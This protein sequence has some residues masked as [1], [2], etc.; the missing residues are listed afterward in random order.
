MNSWLVG[1]LI[2]WFV[3]W[4]IWLIAVWF[5]SLIHWSVD[6]SVGGLVGWVRGWMFD[7]AWD[8][9]LENVFVMC[10]GVVYDVPGMPYA[11][12]RSLKRVGDGIVI[13]LPR[14]QNV[15]GDDPACL[16]RVCSV[17]AQS[18]QRL[19]LPPSL[20]PS[21]PPYLLLRQG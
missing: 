19:P 16:Q 14:T 5:G 15:V 12:I 6:W 9:Q 8:L 1:W 10:V 18:S 20:P 7:V 13:V 2:R 21:L 3:A 4:L 17:R 11:T